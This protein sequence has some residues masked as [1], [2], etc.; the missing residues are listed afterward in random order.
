[1]RTALIAVTTAAA[2]TAAG[3]ALT[4]GT[5]AAGHSNALLEAALDGRSEVATGAS[6]RRV[7][8]DPNGAGEAYVFGVDGDPT[9]LCYVLTVEGISGLEK[10]PGAPYQAHIHEGAAGE[11]G[12]VVANLA[13]PQG[14]NA[15]DCLT[16]GETGKALDRGKV[17]EI[18]SDPSS[19]YVNVHNAEYP[20]GAL[21][22]QLTVQE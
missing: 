5:A 14:G 16:E 9:T 4:V 10:A 12:P 19:Y 22:G 18:L 11:N 17:A 15:A 2:L 6:D 7:V 3:V 1:M 8:G 13:W 20:G 21:R